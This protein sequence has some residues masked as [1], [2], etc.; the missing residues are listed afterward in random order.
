MHYRD[1]G[2]TVDDYMRE[3][4]YVHE[5]NTLVKV[6]DAKGVKSSIYFTYNATRTRRILKNHSQKNQKFLVTE[7]KLTKGEGFTKKPGNQGDLKLSNKQ[8]YC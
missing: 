6:G 1:W 3:V 8:R 4:L 7:G 2:W 5:L